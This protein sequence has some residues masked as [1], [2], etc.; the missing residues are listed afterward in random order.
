MTGLIPNDLPKFFDA[1]DHNVLLKKVYIIGFSKNTVDWFRSC[2][3]NRS[4]L[5]NF[6]NDFSQSVPIR[7][8]RCTPK[9]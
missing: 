5:V 2:L 8:L 9:F 1:T 6:G 3:C 4:F 7:I